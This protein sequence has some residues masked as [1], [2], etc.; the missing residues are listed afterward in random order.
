M[1]SE[2]IFLFICGVECEWF[3]C[4]DNGCYCEG[5][6]WVCMM[7]II[8]EAIYRIKARNNQDWLLWY[9]IRF[10]ENNALLFIIYV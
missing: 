5:C 3:N 8:T 6:Y 9:H 4:M 10:G 1:E 7:A 2:L